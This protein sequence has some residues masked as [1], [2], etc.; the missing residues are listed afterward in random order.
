MQRKI[1][2]YVIARISKDFHLWTDK[3]CDHIEKEFK[4][5]KPKDHNPFSKSH[6]YFSKKVYDL[7]LKFIRSSNIGLILPEYGR[8]C[9][10]EAGW[11]SCSGKPT[12]I[13]V[14]KQTKWL[15]DWMVKGG[16]QYIATINPKTY[17]ILRNDPIL[18]HKRIILLSKISDLNG[19]IKKIGK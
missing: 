1:K 10:W 8:D 9:A 16:L 15:R 4:I 7:D 13:F 19:L 3:V 5:F 18:K 17:K 14:D 2:V 6:K 11:Y 12:I